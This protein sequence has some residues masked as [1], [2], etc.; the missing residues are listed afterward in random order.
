MAEITNKEEKRKKRRNGN[1]RLNL[2]ATKYQ[3][4]ELLLEKL[5]KGW[6][7]GNKMI[8]PLFCVSVKCYKKIVDN[9][10]VLNGFSRIT[11]G[12]KTVFLTTFTDVVHVGKN[13]TAEFHAS[14][15]GMPVD[16][17]NWKTLTL[18]TTGPAIDRIS[19]TNMFNQGYA[20]LKY[21]G[22]SSHHGSSGKIYSTGFHAGFKT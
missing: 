17:T 9:S 10:I 15:R 8:H 18:M 7:E 20:L 2:N 13:I 6:E 12:N 22:G 21:P 11:K 3:E 16:V 19:T 5:L 4:K 1:Q 14:N